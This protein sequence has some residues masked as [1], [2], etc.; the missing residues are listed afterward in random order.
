VLVRFGWA[1]PARPC[2]WR[3]W[4]RV[5]TLRATIHETAGPAVRS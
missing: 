4:N 2:T 1:T 3:L 5:L